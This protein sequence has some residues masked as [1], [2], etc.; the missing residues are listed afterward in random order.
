[1]DL[2]A[3]NRRQRVQPSGPHSRARRGRWVAIALSAAVVVSACTSESGADGTS[4]SIA[5]SATDAPATSTPLTLPAT[6]AEAAAAPVALPTTKLVS[7]GGAIVEIS[8][9]GTHTLARVG[10]LDIGQDPSEGDHFGRF[11]VGAGRSVIAV[12]HRGDGSTAIEWTS[13]N[14]ASLVLD[15]AVDALA[16]D[17]GSW[18]AWVAGDDSAQV[19]IGDRNGVV[20]E[21]ITTSGPVLDLAETATGFIALSSSIGNTTATQVR[22]SEGR[23]T[24]SE[25]IPMSV[26]T[27]TI[28]AVTGD[29]FAAV[30]N[31]SGNSVVSIV[32][33]DGEIVEST[34]AE[35]VISELDFSRDGT[36][37]LGVTD[38]GQQLWLTMSSSELIDDEPVKAGQW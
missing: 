3:F 7:N 13:S 4:D 28:T 32:D 10:A 24:G 30:T 11:D 25:E 15:G 21:T 26:G 31:R 16:A 17:D 23:S 33:T 35:A 5:P 34:V 22:I 36:V 1:M 27:S 14:G 20:T 38:T 6:G 12:L 37:A 8:D 19:L 2:F 29:R 9:T 18:I